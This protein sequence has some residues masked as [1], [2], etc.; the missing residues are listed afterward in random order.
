VELEE[1]GKAGEKSLREPSTIS[2]KSLQIE[3]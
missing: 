2:N 3:V 1:E